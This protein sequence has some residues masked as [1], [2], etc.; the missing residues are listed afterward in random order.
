MGSRA[1]SSRCGR[2]DAAWLVMRR[3]STASLARCFSCTSR[4]ANVFEA[5]QLLRRSGARNLQSEGWSVSPPTAHRGSACAQHNKAPTHILWHRLHAN[6][7]TCTHV[8]SGAQ[9]VFG[10]PVG[11]NRTFRDLG[12]SEFPT[13]M[14]FGR[15][16]CVSWVGLAEEPLG[17]QVHALT[18]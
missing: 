13:V 2:R 11:Y 15:E 9:R 10:H 6:V 4:G 8:S 3:R 16:T 18:L 1:L 14:S 5:S 7:Y 17:V 12:C